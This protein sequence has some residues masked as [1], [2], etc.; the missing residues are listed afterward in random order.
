MPHPCL[1]VPGTLGGAAPILCWQNPWQQLLEKLRDKVK[2]RKGTALT[3]QNPP[4][5]E[6]TRRG[7]KSRM[8]TGEYKG[9]ASSSACCAGRVQTSPE[10]NSFPRDHRGAKTAAPNQSSLRGPGEGLA[11]RKGGWR[12]AHRAEPQRRSFVKSLR[13]GGRFMHLLYPGILGPVAVL[14]L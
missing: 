11:V 14:S 8:C 9:L 4:C 7:R 13:A 3:W 5:E 12:E 6:S 2:P 1:N 10:H